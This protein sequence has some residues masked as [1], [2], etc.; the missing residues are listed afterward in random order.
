MKPAYVRSAVGT[1][2]IPSDDNWRAKTKPITHHPEPREL[3]LPQERRP[4]ERYT[5]VTMMGETRLSPE[6]Y[7]EEN[8]LLPDLNPDHNSIESCLLFGSDSSNSD[9]ESDGNFCSEVKDFSYPS[10]TLDESEKQFEREEY[11][12]SFNWTKGTRVQLWA[13]NMFKD[14]H[15][16]KKGTII[17]SSEKMVQIKLDEGTVIRRMKKVLNK[18]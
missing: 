15:W 5:D 7:F 17:S 4:P 14:P 16:D 13:A 6:E 8:N 2:A 10:S 1:L 11:I 12:A 9:C 18:L 3:R